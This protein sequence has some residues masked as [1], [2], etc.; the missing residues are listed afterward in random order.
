ML[1]AKE[2][3]GFR[4]VTDPHSSFSNWAFYLCG[5]TFFTSRLSFT[6]WKQKKRLEIKLNSFLSAFRLYQLHVKRCPTQ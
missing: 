3:I 1:K 6:K 2:I 5:Q 4:L